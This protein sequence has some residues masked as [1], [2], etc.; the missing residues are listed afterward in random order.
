MTFNI[1]KYI[2]TDTQK[3]THTMCYPTIKT[4][5]IPQEEIPIL[6]EELYKLVSNTA[7]IK[8]TWNAITEKINKDGL[9]KFFIDLDW[10]IDKIVTIP[11]VKNKIIKLLEIFQKKMNEI[12]KKETKMI[13][14]I[15]LFYKIHLYFPSIIVNSEIATKIANTMEEECKKEISELYDDKVID[16]S[17]YKTGLRMI[18]CHKGMLDKT[19]K[20]NEAKA[21]HMKHFEKEIYSEIYY[22]VNHTKMKRLPFKIEQLIETSI[23]T[24]EKE[25]TMI[26]GLINITET[27]EKTTKKRKVKET[28]SSDNMQLVKYNKANDLLNLPKDTL[29]KVIKNDNN[30][31]A[32][33]QCLEC[34]VDP[35]KK[36]STKDH[37]AIIINKDKSV[38][39]TCFSC[40][41]G[42]VMNKTESKKIIQYLNVVVD[43]Q[44]NSVYQELVKDLTNSAK[45]HK[46]KR[47]KKTGIIY[48]PVKKYAY[49]KH[50]TYDP[51]DYINE[52]FLGNELFMSNVNNMD[53]LIKFLKQYDNL[54]FP[55]MKV[56]NDYIGF[57]NGILNLTTLEFIEE[58]DISFDITVKKYIPY[59]FDFSMETP[60]ID[61]LLDYQFSTD[62]RDFLYACFGRMFR[63]RDNLQFMPFLLGEAGCGK[64]TILNIVCT[65]F[66]DIGII[67]TSFETKYGLSY[68]VDKDIIVYDDI[69]HRVD[70]IFPQTEFQS[71][72]SGGK[73]TTAVKNKD[74]ISVDK[75]NIPMLW[76]GNFY[77][78]YLDKGQVSRR[79]IVANFEKNVYCTDTTLMERITTNEIPAFIYKC[80]SLYEEKLVKN[81]SKGIWNIC[82]E[83]FLDQQ[84]ELRSEKNPLFKFLNDN[85]VFKQ[86]NILT[87]ELIR[88]RFGTWLHKPIKKLDNGT[89]GQVNSK[90]VIDIIKTCKHC[91]KKSEKSCCDRYNV[92]DRSRKTVVRNI[93]FL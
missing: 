36:H 70:Q 5:H 63:I 66:D 67:G 27:K 92:N 44:E 6:H 41:G 15:R 4:L 74:A 90:Y 39:K 75:W 38:I 17:V 21:K 11:D 29:W 14:S 2:K 49:I 9:F 78:S 57:S 13:V 62:V 19:N 28:A 20:K 82:P 54:D 16:K 80:L 55:F 12:L 53:N 37:S 7:E 68:F 91:Y 35:C 30:H 40:K 8:C 81:S 65:C 48:K 61:Q 84:T 50:D 51:M 87:M 52:I 22:L 33:P 31:K 10:N 56:S 89:F 25:I 34:L 72:I 59:P 93:D 3:Q 79:L 85:T 32:I 71:M 23:L 58:Y 73:V 45:E 77:P 18:W 83:Y 76:S 69:D 42:G 1:H 43:T 24:D 26:P 47:Q 86:D 88:E 60:L 64:S 46:Y